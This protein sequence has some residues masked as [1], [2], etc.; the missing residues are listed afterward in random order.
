M[1]EK[2]L[3][4]CSA[5]IDR[6]P[7]AEIYFK[8][9]YDTKSCG[10]MDSAPTKISKELID[11][12]DKVFCMEDKHYQKVIEIEPEAESKTI[13]LC[14]EDI[15]IRGEQKLKEKLEEKVRKYL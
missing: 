1:K 8:K 5:N 13:V 10:T 4:I 14:I 12:A 7:T 15:Y 6:S 9:E 11:W 3:F 2:L